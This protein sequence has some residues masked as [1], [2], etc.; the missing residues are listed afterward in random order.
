MRS[1]AHVVEDVRQLPGVDAA[2]V[3]HVPLATLVNIRV[4]GWKEEEVSDGL[5]QH[6]IATFSPE[7]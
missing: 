4:A 5:N 1:H 3:G 2:V 7:H 6:R